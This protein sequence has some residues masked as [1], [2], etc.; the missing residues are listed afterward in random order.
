[1]TLLVVL[2][3]ACSDARGPSLTTAC[4][5]GERG[6]CFDCHLCVSAGVPELKVTHFVCI[7]CHSGD[8][9]GVPADVAGSCGCDT[10]DCSTTPA[11]LDCAVCHTPSSR[12]YP[13][14]E[15]MNG[16]CTECHAAPR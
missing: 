7:D 10:L 15:Y 5:T 11:T 8:T 13:S 16:L 3:L 6:L 9:G 4:A 14:Q 2:L 12:A 1:M